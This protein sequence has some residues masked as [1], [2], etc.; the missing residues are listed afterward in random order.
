MISAPFLGSIFLLSSF[1]VFNFLL[2]VFFFY[3]VLI[4]P[5]FPISLKFLHFCS[6]SQF[7]SSLPSF[8]LLS[9]LVSCM[10]SF[11]QF[12]PSSALNRFL[13]VILSL[14]P[15]LYCVDYNLESYIWT[16][17]LPYT[18]TSSAQRNQR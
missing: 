6:P 3:F 5:S 18:F 11:F 12:S 2:T 9:L 13:Q 4:L 7:R 1:P 15:F 10:S 14:I 16:Y 8:L 17:I